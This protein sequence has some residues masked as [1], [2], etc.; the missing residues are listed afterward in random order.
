MARVRSDSRKQ[1]SSELSVQEM[2]K[3]CMAREQRIL[4]S[5]YK[6]NVHSV[7][8]NSLFGVPLFW[9]DPIGGYGPFERQ[10]SRSQMPFTFSVAQ[11]SYDESS[12]PE[13]RYSK[14]LELLRAEKDLDLC[15]LILARWMKQEKVREPEDF[16]PKPILDRLLRRYMQSIRAS[17]SDLSHWAAVTA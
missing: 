7:H 9:P 1:T 5:N 16:L 17:A 8:Q 13:W 4:G 14:L 15:W 10:F 3:D 6:K 2:F 11:Y 12:T